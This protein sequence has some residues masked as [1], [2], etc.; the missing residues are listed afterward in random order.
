MSLDISITSNV[1]DA[2]TAMEKIPDKIV[3]DAT[4]VSINRAMVTGR[5]EAG[6]TL[7]E[8]LNVKSRDMKQK[9]KVSKARGG[10]LRSLQ[11]V[12]SFDDTPM[13]LIDFVRGNKNLIKQK[14]VKIK[15]RR[16]LKVE[17]TRGKKFVIKGGF[18]QKARSKQLFKRGSSGGFYKQSAPS[19]GEF[20]MRKQ[21]K[22]PVAKAM[23]Q[24]FRKN[25]KNQVDF[26]MERMT[27]KVGAGRM[28]RM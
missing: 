11:G 23:R 7:R 16:K 5:K 20:I 12:L 26:R 21:F 15:K 13:P 19:V 6:K 14:G 27:A 28:R 9:I 25:L 1:V 4:R 17:I 8:R 10:N 24:S 3:W 18:I 22:F 2:I